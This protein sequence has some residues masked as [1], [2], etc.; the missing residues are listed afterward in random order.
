M[1]HSYN[2]QNDVYHL[3][4]IFHMSTMYYIILAGRGPMLCMA[5]TRPLSLRYINVFVTI[6]ASKIMGY[7]M[8]VLL[9]NLIGLIWPHPQ[10]HLS[11]VLSKFLVAKPPTI[12]ADCGR[13]KMHTY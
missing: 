4:Y 7:L 6:V 1:T 11:L 12:M 3:M 8:F 10:T 5:K 9:S 2:F 13:Y